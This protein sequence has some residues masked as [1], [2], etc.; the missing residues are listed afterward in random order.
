MKYD[1]ELCMKVSEKQWIES[2]RNGTVCFNPIEVFIKKAEKNGNNEQGDRYEGIFARLQTNDR[3]I[4]EL[5]IRF[6]DDL[7]I[8]PENNN[9]VLLR[10]KSSRKIPIFCMYGVRRDELELQ[11]DSVHKENG[12][13]IGTVVYD[14][15]T[16]IYNG[17][18][19]SSDVWGFYASSGHF[20]VAL[21]KALGDNNLTYGKA[22]I[23]YDIELD[24]EFYFEPTENY[25]EL[26]HKRKE[27]EY[28]HE[29]RYILPFSPRDEKYLLKYAPLAEN[30]CGIA[31]GELKLEMRCICKPLED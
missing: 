3:R 8:I 10:R 4:G 9:Y 28:Q 26:I 16:R 21:E 7:E 27:L 11:E 23:N 19:N 14:F 2:L 6:G 5:K 25:S 18:L 13:Y 31:R 24:K 12:K 30:S 17:F 15:P 22:V 29:I 20:C 1:I